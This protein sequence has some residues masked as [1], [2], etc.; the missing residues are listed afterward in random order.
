MVKCAHAGCDKNTTGRAVESFGRYMGT[1][2]ECPD[3]HLS[4]HI[5]KKEETVAIP[6]NYSNIFTAYDQVTSH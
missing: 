6:A 3:G 2:C 4:V 5:P 1:I